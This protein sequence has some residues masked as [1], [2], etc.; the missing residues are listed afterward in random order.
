MN[1]RAASRQSIIALKTNKLRSFL[2]I[3]GI[4]IG[5][6]SVMMILSLGMGL[7]KMVVSE[8]ESFGSNVLDIA[9]KVPGT[10]EMGTMTSMAKGVEVTTLKTRDIKDLRDKDKFPYITA[11]MGE[12]FGQKYVKY[13]NE[14]G[15]TMLYGTNADFPVVFKTMDVKEGRFLS[16]R[17]NR[18]LSQVAV[19]GSKMKE[20]LFGDENPIGKE[21]KI[22]SRNFEVVGTLEPYGGV[23][24]GGI[25]INKFIYIPVETALSKI[26]GTD[27]LVEMALTVK[28]Q[29]YI[30]R[31]KKEI[32]RLLRH[33]HNIKNPENDDF[34][35]TTMG[36]VLSRVGDVTTI[37]NI[38]LGFLAAISLIV[39]G[40]GIMNVML[41]SVSERT[42]EI[43]LRKAVGAS[44][45]D[46]LIHF[47]T[48][49][50]IITG[51]GGL[52]GIIVG[53]AGSVA[54]G[55]IIKQ[56]WLAGWPIT[57]SWIATLVAILISVG[58]GLISSIY[59]AR[60]AAKLNPIE[61]LRKA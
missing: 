59:P 40:V 47:L 13:R 55:F 39:G 31:A 38:L 20:K 7:K 17:E 25:D 22:G 46:I 28:G 33:N 53:G 52:I 27:H 60:K 9:V 34:Q 45:K 42:K 11:V 54:A 6:A 30:P 26:L 8:V 4:I 49:G 36:E 21:I 24:F 32:A 18:S 14:E 23:A 12:V 15:K 19:L 43:G 3:I 51:V 29:S 1:I 2:S 61:S 37:L 50:V 5:V 56:Q 41:A 10:G 48:E 35:I 57:I 16:K 58:I 44:N